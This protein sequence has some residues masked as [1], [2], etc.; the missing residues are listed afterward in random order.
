MSGDNI[1]NILLDTIDGQIV[2]DQRIKTRN[3]WQAGVDSFIRIHVKRLMLHMRILSK[4]NFKRKKY[5]WVAY[6]L[7]YPSEAVMIATGKALTHKFTDMFK[8]CEDCIF[9]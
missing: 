4:L 8:T 7:V 1:K 9:V 2:L 3:E 5:K 6:K